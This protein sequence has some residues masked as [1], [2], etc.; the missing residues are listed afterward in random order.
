MIWN[1]I[2]VLKFE[3]VIN[4]NLTYLRIYIQNFPVELPLEKFYNLKNNNIIEL[5]YKK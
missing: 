1:F 2:K 4:N 5:F 3:Y